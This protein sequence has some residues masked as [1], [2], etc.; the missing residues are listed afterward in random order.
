MMTPASADEPRDGARTDGA[1]AR[2]TAPEGGSTMQRRYDRLFNTG[3]SRAVGAYLRERIYATF[4]GLAI[5]L[6]V[7]GSDHAAA[8]HALLALLF[9]VIGITIAGFVSDVVSHLAVEGE[10]P[11]G[12]DWV[13]LLRVAGG[14]LSTVVVP[15]GL[16]LLGWLEI[17]DL[18][19][20]ISAAAIVYVV[21]LALIGWLAVRRSHARWWERVL[22]LGILIGLGLLVIALQTLAKLV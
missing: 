19:T 5:V 16:M 1:P 14:G 12:A 2:S 21:T 3:G 15:G 4:T 6:V 17:I 13:V 10:F 7:A 11:H 9:G 20:A 8:D 18:S 22:A